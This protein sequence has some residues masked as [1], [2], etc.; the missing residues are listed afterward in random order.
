MRNPPKLISDIH[1]IHQL[2]SLSSLSSGRLVL[3]PFIFYVIQIPHRRRTSRMNK[4]RSECGNVTHREMCIS[5]FI[6]YSFG[7]SH[8]HSGVDAW[9]VAV[10]AIIIIIIAYHFLCAFPCLAT[11]EL[12]HFVFYALHTTNRIGSK[13]ID[14]YAAK[15]KISS[16]RTHAHI[17]HRLTHRHI[18]PI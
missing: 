7:C 5:F 12:S 9:G 14:E 16:K 18:L 2:V 10:W 1:R 11:S 6:L 17:S 13:R 8:S 4:W 15:Q 3:S